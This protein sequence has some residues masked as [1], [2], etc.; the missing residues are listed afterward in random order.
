MPMDR[1][2][3]RKML[4]LANNWQQRWIRDIAGHL[5][6]FHFTVPS[7]VAVGSKRECGA[8]RGRG[9]EYNYW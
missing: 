2:S 6:C 4:V 3:Y 1:K 7:L 8:C 9:I 5:V